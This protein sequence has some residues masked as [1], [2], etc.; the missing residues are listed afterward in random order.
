MAAAHLSTGLAEGPTVANAAEERKI[1]HY[2]DLSTTHV[3][4][5]VAIETLGGVGIR[6]WA[7]I[8]ELAKRISRQSRDKREF[9]YLR[10]RLG[11]AVQRGNAAC[12][13]EPLTRSQWPFYTFFM[14][15]YVLLAV[16]VD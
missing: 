10:Q 7:F 8:W 4:E 5:P 3:F 9:Q 11:I 6:S 13:M 16:R 15:D 1:N 14:Q 12:A 2:A